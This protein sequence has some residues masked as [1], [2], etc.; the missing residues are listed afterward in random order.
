MPRRNIGPGPGKYMLPPV[1]GY[2][3]HD[4]SKY[5]NPQYSIGMKLT[6]GG[7]RPPGPG[8]QYDVRNMTTYGKISPPAYTIKSRAKPL[9]GFQVP[10]PG[11]YKNELVPR[12]KEKRPPAYSMSI[13]YPP[14]RRMQIPGPDT[15]K[16]PTTI[17]PKVP[18]LHANAA[19]SLSYK[20]NLIS[21]DQSPGPAKYAGIN[22]NVYKY[23]HPNYTVSPRVFPPGSKPAGPGPI[24]L[25]KL[26]QKPGYSFGIRCDRDPYITTADDMPCTLRVTT[27]PALEKSHAGKM[28][29][30]SVKEVFQRS[31][32]KHNLKYAQYIG[33]GDSKTSKATL[34]LDPYNNDP[35]VMKKE[36]V[37][38]V[39]KNAWEPGSVM[40]R[41][42]TRDSGEEVQEH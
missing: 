27:V 18:D 37:G 41:K 23:K 16:L 8:P 25:P 33:D 21:K 26:P 2:R 39:E 10:G 38:H 15:Y 24:Y 9:S 29:V 35:K 31:E 28:E 36:R 5:R 17:G 11:T 32:E 7:K 12:M 42:Q 6:G 34:D 19:Y 13:R 30:D 22:T 20:H 14:L 40:R 1:T 3:N 4:Y